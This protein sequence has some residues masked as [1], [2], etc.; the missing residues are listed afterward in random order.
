MGLE[1][2]RKKGNLEKTKERGGGEQDQSGKRALEALRNVFESL[3]EEV[4]LKTVRWKMKMRFKPIDPNAPLEDILTRYIKD[5]LTGMAKMIQLPSPFTG[6]RKQQLIHKISNHLRASASLERVV[7]GLSGDESIALT[8][9]MLKDG[10]MTWDEFAEKY[11]GDLEESY[12]WNYH[13]PETV[14]GRLKAKGLIAVGSFRGE[15]WVIVPRELRPLLRLI[16]ALAC[17]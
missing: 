15:E 13:Q 16:H 12:H 5:G 14:M 11:G 2:H 17:C 6:L 3:A 9:L 10:F 7:D 8:D 1:E 4:R